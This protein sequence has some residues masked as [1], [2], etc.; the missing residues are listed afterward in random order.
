MFPSNEI[1]IHK[2]KVLV[3]QALCFK[4]HWIISQTVV[5]HLAILSTTEL[6]D[7][8]KSCFVAAYTALFDRFQKLASITVLPPIESI[9]NSNVFGWNG[10]S[11]SLSLCSPRDR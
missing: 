1:L 2:I 3:F 4:K 6:N 5:S 10:K 9:M 8:A 11:S 7:C